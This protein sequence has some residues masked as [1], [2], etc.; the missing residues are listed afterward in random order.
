MPAKPNHLFYAAR[1]GVYTSFLP[2]KEPATALHSFVETYLSWSDEGGPAD[3]RLLDTFLSDAVSLHLL[4]KV[5][6][7]LKS[8]GGKLRVL[9]A[10]PDSAFACA[11]G[12]A[13]GQDPTKELLTGVANLRTALQDHEVLPRP[14]MRI[15]RNET[16]SEIVGSFDELDRSENLSVEVR[17]YEVAPS[18]PMYFFDDLLITSRFS[19]GSSSVANP[20]WLVVNDDRIDNDLYASYYNEFDKIWAHAD[21]DPIRSNAPRLLSEE[22]QR[23]TVLAVRIGADITERALYAYAA[24]LAP[25]WEAVG[26]STAVKRAERNVSITPWTDGAIVAFL[27]PEHACLP[28]ELAAELFQR[29]GH[30]LDL[31]YA[32][33]R[34]SLV[35]VQTGTFTRHCVGAPNDLAGS[36]S[37]R[38]ESHCVAMSEQYY[39]DYVHEPERWGTIDEG[40]PQ[41]ATDLLGHAYQYRVL[42]LTKRAV[43][44]RSGRS[45]R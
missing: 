38:V 32:I 31:R 17:F 2:G 4:S 7:Q 22:E 33:V 21:A 43:H 39:R 25:L 10:A 14:G 40:P 8:R 36:L 28:L 12:Q 27:D 18:A 6:H 23:A 35:L 16:L 34:G 13:I 1:D 44:S 45:S 3:F 42:R 30:E 11:R 5:V 24:T 19:Y 15:G 37:R 41:L 26:N 29:Y 20:W 9:L